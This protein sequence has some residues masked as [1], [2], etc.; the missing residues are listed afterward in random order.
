M[1]T[2]RLFCFSCQV[3]DLDLDRVRVEEEQDEDI[4]MIIY[5]LKSSC[6]SRTDFELLNGIVY[7][8]AQ[9]VGGCSWLYVPSSL[10]TETLKLLHSHPLAGHPGMRKTRR[11]V[12]RN[13]FW[14]NSRQDIDNFIRN[15]STCNIHKGNVNVRAHLEHYPTTLHPFQVVAMDH[16][17]PL[18]TTLQG[19]KYLLVFVCHLTKYL[20]IVSVGDRTAHSVAEALMSCIVAR[21]SCPEVLLSDNAPEFVGE[22]LQ[23]VR[24]NYQIKK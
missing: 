16:M 20:E 10:I 21:H 13:Y 2:T 15:C 4:Q 7:K 22:V 1:V 18:P 24:E 14:P 5:D 3:V 17:G 8:K 9:V 12:S 19:N 23:K 11:I 6:N